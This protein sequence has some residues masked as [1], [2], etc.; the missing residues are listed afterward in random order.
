MKHILSILFLLLAISFTYG[1]NSTITGMVYDQ[2]TNE[3]LPGVNVV[4]KN[5]SNGTTTD[6][7][8]N[9]SLSNVGIG[10]VLVFS[11]ISFKTTEIEIRNL[12]AITVYMQED[13]SALDEVVV[14]GY[15]TQTKKEVTG[16]VAVVG[17]QTIEELNPTRIE[18]A[19][20]GQIS[21][22][23]ITS[24]SGSP[25]SGSNIRI[26]GISTN[27]DNRPLILVDGNVI[28]DLSVLNPG[29]IES[30]N[31]LKDATAGIY[32]VRAANGV[33]LITTKTG[34]KNSEL[35]FSYDAYGGFQQTSR[36]IPVLNATEYAVLINEAFAANGQPN[37][38]PNFAG[39]G[40]GTDWQDE[41]F[42]NAPIFNHNLTING[43][44]E[45][46]TYSFG[47]SLLTQDGIVGG[48]KANFKRYT[49]RV[50]FNTDLLENLKLTA[51]LLYTGTERK[52]LSENAIGSVLFNALNNAPTFSVRD[53]NGD[54]TLAE[55]L[56]NEV[57]NPIAQV[58]NTFNANKVD[59]LSGKFALNYKFL[60]DFTVETSLQFNYAEVQGRN[61]S[62]TVFY[63]SG[64]V[65]N[66]IG[67]NSLA[68]NKD[69]FRDYTFDAFLNY[70]KTLN[71][72]HNFQ[73][74]LGTSVFRTTGLF[75]GTTTGFFEN[76]VSFPEADIANTVDQRN[77][78]VDSGLSGKFDERL[79]SYFARVQYDYKGKYLFS[80]VIRR[81]G[82]TKFGPENRFGYFPSGSVGWIAS[83]ENFLKENK[84][85]NFLK[86][87]GSY[88][89]LGND[90]IASNGFRGVLGGEAAYVLNGEL[91]FGQAV[92]VLPNPAI[93]WEEQK[94]YDIGLD[95]RLF[96]D[97]IDITADYFNKTT[98][99]LLLQPQV[100]GIL[101]ASAPGAQ[102][103][104]V[105]GGTVVNKGIEFA[106]GYKYS[107]SE[108]FSLGVNYNVTLLENEVTEV[109]N[110]AG[111]LQGG[112]FG[113]GQDPPARMEAGKP[114][115]Y[116]FGLET[117]G[118]FQNQGEVDAHATQANAA[119]GDLR[120][121]DQNGDNVIDSDDRVDIGNPI[122]D[123]TMGL[124]LS[125]TYKNFDFGTYAFASIGNEIVRNYE[126]NQPLV[127]KSVYAL[128][129]WTGEG[130]TNTYPR[131]TTGATSN[132]LFSDFYVEDGSF[133][134]LQNAQLGYT[135]SNDFMDRFGADKLRV[136]V[137]VN[138]IYTFTKYRGYDPSASSGAPIGA[139]IDQGFYPVP[140]TYLLGVNL[141][142]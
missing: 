125:I 8:G 136:Y 35:K 23:N 98:D 53:A 21:G 135:F 112:G 103:P 131:V 69:L 46:S 3:P 133:V 141:K 80:G 93:Q 26:R 78:L 45:K 11:Y 75:S 119:P 120:F 10:D 89:I 51:N 57:I 76:E 110:E 73:V 104:I 13:V 117:D 88:G 96:N 39:L 9:F 77:G 30:I 122:P 61:F 15:G 6:F 37:P 31:V 116:F 34:R 49:T 139:G 43:G 97:A 132:T 84:T 102:A 71:G 124:N 2:S 81:D 83:D 121:V 27:G 54:Y 82:S 48:N 130:S 44:S 40:T 86:L 19:L 42:Q 137:S 24:E 85:I 128:N 5:T 12:N 14:I 123:A 92:G 113:V 107:P 138:N 38:Y 47:A 29:D 63:G 28:E 52:T 95:L 1:Q 22:V 67:R 100:S 106:I 32:G 56:G 16:A 20:Q 109:N 99:G 4:V 59:R 33:V 140:R 64:K 127:N 94:T 105:N 111:F 36:T 50:N 41:V 25:G 118:V 18:Q 134:R 74:T 55:G 68:V 114:I 72:D 62:P 129:R 79:L 91:V 101:G 108:D 66:N 60:E 90:R 7:D 70:T 87:R 142:F 58:A 17:S 126:R 65:F 115:G